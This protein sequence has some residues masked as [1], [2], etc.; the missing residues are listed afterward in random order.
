MEPIEA[1]RGKSKQG[2]ENSESCDRVI[3]QCHTYKYVSKQRRDYT[4]GEQGEVSG[5][6]D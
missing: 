1:E 6:I 5:I 4:E 3:C 2:V